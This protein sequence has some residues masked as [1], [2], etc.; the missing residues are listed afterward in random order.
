MGSDPVSRALGVGV[1]RAR[2]DG[3]LEHVDVSVAG[4]L[5][6]A[7]LA[8]LRAVARTEGP[9]EACIGAA[10]VVVRRDGDAILGLVLLDPPPPRFEAR[11]ENRLLERA[12]DG[13]VLVRGGEILRATKRAATLLGRATEE[14]LIGEPL[15]K[16]LREGAGEVRLALPSGER[17]VE[18]V[19]LPIVH[20]GEDAEL[21]LV[22][23][24]T[25]QR[26]LQAKLTQSD[27]LATVGTLA[28]SVAHEI[29]NPL[30][31]VMHY[32][33]R[34]RR[35]LEDLSEA[36][37]APRLAK[38]REG[39]ETAAEGVARVRDIVRDLKTFGRVDDGE[40]VPLD[41]NRALRSALQMAGH[42]IRVVARLEVELGPLPAVRANDGRLCQVF[43]NLLMNAAQAIRPGTDRA[44]ARI[45]VKSWSER[46]RVYVSIR[47]TGVGIAS[48]HLARLFEPFFS[49][50]PD[51]VGTG[52]GLWICRDIVTDLGGHIDVDSAPGE[53]TTMTVVLPRATGTAAFVSSHPPPEP[54]SG[55]F[56][57]GT[58]RR[59]LVVDDEPAVLELL[60]EAL[61]EHAD[62]VTAADGNEAREI[63]RHDAEFDAILCDL[64]MP[65]MGGVELFDWVDR[66]RP[67]L[68]ARMI[69]MTGAAYSE[70]A[71]EFLARVD[72]ERLDKPFRVRDVERVLD[73]VIDGPVRVH[74]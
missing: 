70:D 55:P 53:G 20:E 66:A 2:D 52:L 13:V 21:I 67:K 51:G 63:L 7:A 16:G 6:E 34:L 57:L 26:Y 12:Q 11:W 47:D 44:R 23:D 24:L 8:Q 22:R 19:R 56:Q 28:A 74:A 64:M 9:V 73:R 71:R 5:D 61:G 37:D 4:L 46:G 49:T 35:D 41:V 25:E 14:E 15:P 10:R 40:D 43:L 32:I 60:A 27:R 18:S 58:L 54:I 69:F 68:A 62:V 36:V 72:N 39:A 59:V 45:E 65:G 38:L 42:R 17:T 1:F 3:V 31:Y 29:N 50:K 48:E 33:D 30:T